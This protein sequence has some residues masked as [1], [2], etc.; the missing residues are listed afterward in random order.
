MSITN[1]TSNKN[2][3]LQHEHSNV[4][5]ELV[6]IRKDNPVDYGDGAPKKSPHY[7]AG[8]AGEKLKQHYNYEE[9][10]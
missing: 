3:G 6:L 2:Q 10:K 7:N 8:P 5:G 9:Q 4:K 1:R